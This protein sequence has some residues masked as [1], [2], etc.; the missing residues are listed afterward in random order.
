MK[1]TKNNNVLID[2]TTTCNGMLVQGGVCGRVTSYPLSGV[3]KA[4]GLTRE[5]IAVAEP[6]DEA[7]AYGAG[8]TISE[9]CGIE[10]EG[11]IIRKGTI[12][13]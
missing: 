2:Y 1:I 6:T 4:T 13:R 3:I 12:I 8:V 7:P 10:M 5:Q 9:A 11:K